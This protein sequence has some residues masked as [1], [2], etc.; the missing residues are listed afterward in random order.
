MA[1]YQ[2]NTYKT[3]AQLVSEVAVMVGFRKPD[4]PAGS[5]D[6]AVQ[7]MVAAVNMAGSDMLNLYDWQNLCKP[8]DM[9]IVADFDGQREKAFDLP[10]DFWTFIDQTQW[11]KTT[12]LPAIGSVSPQDWQQ[13]QVRNPKVVMT[14]LWQVRENKL[15][16]QSPPSTP[17]VFTFVYISRGWVIDADNPNLIKNSA[18]KNGDIVQF[19]AYLMALLARAKWQ[20][21]K[22]FDATAANNDFRTNYELRKGKANGGQ[23]LSMT[24][25]SG[26]PY[27][28]MYLNAPDTGY[29]GTNA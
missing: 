16:I 27:L 20:Q 1:D 12:Q 25:V 11:N 26:L 4:D 22:G 21:M 15:W 19:D 29:G 6:P 24:K 18:T 3:L 13:L 23:I 8:W 14:F 5:E 10:A 28:N 17:Q 7:Q 9:E 2:I